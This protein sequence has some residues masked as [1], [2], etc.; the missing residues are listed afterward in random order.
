[1]NIYKCNLGSNCTLSLWDFY[2]ESKIIIIMMSQL[3]S[4][5]KALYVVYMPKL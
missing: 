5:Y 2:I 1:M 3:T 4:K